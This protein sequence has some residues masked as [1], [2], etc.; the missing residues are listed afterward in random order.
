MYK[1][2]SV[3]IPTY[4]MEEYLKGCLDSFILPVQSLMSSLEVLVVIDGATDKSSS[5]AHQY[6]DRYPETFRV[7]DKENGNYGSC[8]NRG[9]K[10]ATGKYIRILDADDSYNTENFARFLQI[11]SSIDADLI[12]SDYNLVDNNG[13]ILERRSFDLETMITTDIVKVLKPVSELEMHAITYRRQILLDINYHQTEGISYTDT[14]WAF[15]PLMAVNTVCYVNLQIYNYLVGRPGQTMDIS[16]L[17]KSMP[18]MMTVYKRLM[19]IYNSSHLDAH[20]NSILF[21]HRIDGFVERTYGQTLYNKVLDKDELKRLDEMV[22]KYKPLLYEALGNLNDG[23]V[24]YVKQ[25]R[26]HN[27]SLPL[28]CCLIVRFVQLKRKYL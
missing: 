3:V 13:N 14:E 28:Y 26:R 19:Q 20:K 11:L 15:I 17:R 21:D 10:V 18:Q 5:I 7:I 1:I 22:K 2:L 24:W 8:I 12:L 9:L 4:N 6:Q 25:W 27:Y 23:Y 16:V